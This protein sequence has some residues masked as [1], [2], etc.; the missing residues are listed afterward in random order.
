MANKPL[1]GFV[2]ALLLCAAC[3]E[4]AAAELL[5]LFTTPA[6]R[7][8]INSNRYKSDTPV[9]AIPRPADEPSVEAPSQQRIMEEV[10]REYRVS[11]IT[12]SAEGSHTVWVNNVAYQDGE[13]MPDKSRLK[14]LSGDKV[15]LRIT[16]PDGKAYFASAGE[17]LKITYLAPAGE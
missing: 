6:E 5:T 8:I 10:S 3:G 14:I 1:S 17:T 9:P 13:Q 11:G 15:R 2:S 12:L 16:A 7:Q 4:L